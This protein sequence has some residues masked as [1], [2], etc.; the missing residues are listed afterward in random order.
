MVSIFWL[1]KRAYYKVCVVF[2]C[3]FESGKGSHVK[4]DSLVNSLYTKWKNAGKN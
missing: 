3:Q 1:K 4:L 2:A